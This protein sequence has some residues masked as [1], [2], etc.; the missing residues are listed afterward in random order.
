MV[1]GFSPTAGPKKSAGQIER[2]TLI[3]KRK[4]GM[5]S[6]LNKRQIGQDQLDRQDIEMFYL[7]RAKA[8]GQR[9]CLCGNEF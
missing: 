4:G 2:E 5:D 8:Q 7:I 1:S 3:F 6:C 9:R